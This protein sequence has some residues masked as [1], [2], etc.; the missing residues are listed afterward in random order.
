[1]LKWLLL[2]SD[3][4]YVL[5]NEAAHYDEDIK[6]KVD[7]MCEEQPE[8]GYEKNVNVYNIYTITNKLKVI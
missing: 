7:N 5:N 8:Q 1:M 3:L 6:K 4:P 2:S